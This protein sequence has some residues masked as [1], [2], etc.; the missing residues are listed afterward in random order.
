LTYPN[1]P[2]FA[3][4]V[5]RLA[6][7]FGGEGQDYAFIGTLAVSFYGAPRTT[8]DV[9]VIIAVGGGAKNKNTI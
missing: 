4:F 8:S 2:K 7:A 1:R 9:D 6:E 3:Q 5:N